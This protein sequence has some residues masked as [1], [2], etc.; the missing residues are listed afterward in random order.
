[1]CHFFSSKKGKKSSETFL[2]S[3]P[4]GVNV[5]VLLA[6]GAKVSASEYFSF[7]FVVCVYV[8]LYALRDCNSDC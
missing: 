8:S 3:P 5:H 1:M 6:A 2:Q 4:P 7:L